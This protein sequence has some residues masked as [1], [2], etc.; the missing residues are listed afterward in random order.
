MNIKVHACVGGTVVK[1]DIRI[2]KHGV[3]VVVGTPGRIHDM[4]KRGFMKTD[5]LKLFV[6]DEADEML[7]RGFKQQIQDIFKFLPGDI[8]IALF[9]ATLPPDILRLTKH[10][11]REPAKILVKNQEL[12]LE[13]IHQYY[14]AV[15]KEDWKI[16]VLLNLYANL[17]INQ[18]LIYCNTKKR[19]EEL[20]KSMTEQDFVV[21]IMHG[22]MDQVKRD[23]VMKQF[24][25]GA[26]RVLITTDL[27]AR[28]IDV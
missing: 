1:E 11:M 25:Q 3:H 2:L 15:E 23:I 5:Y 18:A 12:T 16:E 17:D 22:E 10:F 9:S 13:G 14:I 24:R 26:V 20:E 27:L 7:S 28:G 19:V 4:M 8:Q 6:L 21:S